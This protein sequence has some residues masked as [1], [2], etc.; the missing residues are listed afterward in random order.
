MGR[1]YGRVAGLSFLLIPPLT[2]PYPSAPLPSRCSGQAGQAK[3]GKL[4]IVDE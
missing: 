4:G 2:P 3:E 1:N